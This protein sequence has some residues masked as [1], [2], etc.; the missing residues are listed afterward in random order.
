MIEQLQKTRIEQYFEALNAENFETAA[1]LFAADGVL[2]PPFHEG[3]VGQEAIA[4]YLEEEAKGIKLFPSQYDVQSSELS[5]T[6]H[7]ITGK[8]QTSLFYV[9]ASWRII[10]NKDSEIQ[11]VKVKLLASLTELMSLK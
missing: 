11:S 8:V 1:S 2:Y 5:C 10:L 7:T 3:V 9:N 4:Q 6:E